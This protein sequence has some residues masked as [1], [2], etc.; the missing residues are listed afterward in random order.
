MGDPT[1]KR[2]LYEKPKKLWNARRIEEELSLRTEFGLRNAKELWR[3][4]TLLRKI[5]REARRLLSGKGVD[6][7]KRK[8]QLL[9]RVKS[10]LIQKDLV[11]L[12]D[13]LSL[14]TR[15][16]LCRRLETLVWKKGFAKSP[17]QARQFITHGHIAI[18]GNRVSAPS[19]LVKFAEEGGINWYK[20][21]MLVLAPTPGKAVEAAKA[22]AGAA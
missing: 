13:V 9:A 18:S 3:M 2:K 21:P 11:S 1:R 10:F 22:A 16:M 17:V 15:D 4:Q 5:R 12:D 14:T 7:E 20:K 8:A 6:V 19:Y